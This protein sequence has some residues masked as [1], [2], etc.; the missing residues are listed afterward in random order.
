MK[1][2]KTVEALQKHALASGSEVIDGTDRFNTN[3][4]KMGRIVLPPAPTLPSQKGQPSNWDKVQRLNEGFQPS[5]S[6]KDM[7]HALAIQAN[8][9]KSALE[10]L[11]KSH[12]LALAEISKSIAAL[13][14]RKAVNPDMEFEVKYGSNGEIVKICRKVNH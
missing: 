3:A 7:D 14:S 1:T 8:E 9:F 6:K 2:I 11:A 4:L 10:S 5:V 12:Q 13:A